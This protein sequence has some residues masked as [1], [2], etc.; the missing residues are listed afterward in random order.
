M[1]TSGQGAARGR[2]RADG[3]VCLGGGG[4]EWRGDG[5]LELAGV[6]VDGGGVL[7]VRGGELANE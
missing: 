7:G 1:T 2:G 4:L 3:G 6:Q 5:E